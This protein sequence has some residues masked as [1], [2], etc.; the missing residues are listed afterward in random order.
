M[1]G[2]ITSKG[3]E[4]FQNKYY[5][6]LAEKAENEESER[7]LRER[8]SLMNQISVEQ[9]DEQIKINRQLLSYQKINIIISGIAAFGIIIGI[10]KGCNW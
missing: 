2:A 1:D 6:E 8:D 7:E 5:L 10:L 4:L 9:T 3:N